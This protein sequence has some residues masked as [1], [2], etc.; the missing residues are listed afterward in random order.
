MAATMYTAEKQVN[1]HLANQILQNPN[2]G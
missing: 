1:L 2:T